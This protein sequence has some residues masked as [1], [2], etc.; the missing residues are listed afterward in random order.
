MFNLICGNHSKQKFRKHTHCVI[1]TM[2]S[3]V[4]R[5]QIYENPFIIS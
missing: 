4:E 5:I 3:S 2:I 1:A